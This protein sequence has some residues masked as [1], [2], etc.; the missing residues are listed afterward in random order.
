MA[1]ALMGRPAY[2]LF[3]RNV[4]NFVRIRIART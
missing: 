3:K 2:D 1:V 4:W